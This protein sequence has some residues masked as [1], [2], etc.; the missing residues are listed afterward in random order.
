M[1]GAATYWTCWDLLPFEPVNVTAILTDLRRRTGQDFGAD[2][3]AWR[4]WFL[5]TYPSDEVGRLQV[6]YAET[7]RRI[8]EIERGAQRNLGR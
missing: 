6:E 1:A 4:A 3:R 2:P 8:R 5:S 7:R